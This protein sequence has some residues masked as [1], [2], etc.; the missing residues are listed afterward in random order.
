MTR[1][2]YCQ[3]SVFHAPALENP[4]V[5]LFLHATTLYG[6][7][8]VI[9]IDRTG[10]ITTPVRNRSLFPIP[11]FRTFTKSYEEVC[12]DRAREILGSAEKLGVRIYV[13]YSGGIDSTCLL[14]SLLKQAT[15]QQ[16]KNIVVLLS[17]ESIA[18]NPRFYEEHIR[19]KL[20]VES[21][22]MFVNLLGGNDILLS[23]ELNDQVLGSDLIAKM[24]AR[25][26]SSVIHKPYDR[27]QVV[28]IFSDILSGDTQTA[29]FYLDLFERIRE[30][31]PVPIDTN[32]EFLWWVNFT[33]KWQACLLYVLLFTSPRNARAVTKDY[34][35]TRF[36]AFYNT[37]EFQ[38]WALNNL[39]K[40]IKDSWASYKWVAKEVIYDY[41]RDAEYRDNKTKVAS[42]NV[43][44]RQHYVP[45]KL[46]D[47]NMR[48]SNDFAPETYLEPRNDFV[49]A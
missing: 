8:W 9:P 31:A 12:D 46:L 6:G 28:A 20:K 16:K 18:E 42:R 3:P 41:T 21:S 29:A 33:T 39:D 13:L 27:S 10:T 32:F 48:F 40:R 22:I 44:L 38:L 36:L 26:G 1:L 17:H 14:I 35:D 5:A 47:E 2:I 7:K 30:V 25:Y 24:I 11:E 45:N 37:D 19:G 43:I 4:G 15:P 34:L 49:T 23:A